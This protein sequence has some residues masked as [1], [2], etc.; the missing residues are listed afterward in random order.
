MLGDCSVPMQ[1]P[2]LRVV[3]KWGGTHGRRAFR[4]GAL[5]IPRPRRP[6]PSSLP[7]HPSCSRLQATS[8]PAR[9]PNIA[10]RARCPSGC[11]QEKRSARRRRLLQS[12]NRPS[13]PS[14]VAEEG[15]CQ[16]PREPGRIRKPAAPAPELPLPPIVARAWEKL[17]GSHGAEQWARA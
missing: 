10:N 7:G 17:L 8:E 1:C 16:L 3:E 11:G 9:T 14:P 15:P 5:A 6:C 13:A 4:L 12:G 2:D